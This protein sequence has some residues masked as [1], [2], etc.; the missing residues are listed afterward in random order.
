MSATPP[1]LLRVPEAARLLGVGRTTLYE[2][3]ARGELRP[4]HIGRAVRVE[5]AEVEAFVRRASA[6]A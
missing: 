5:R 3:L 2:M 4:V 6:A 1:L